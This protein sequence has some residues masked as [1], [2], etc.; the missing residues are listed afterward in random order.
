MSQISHL[1]LNGL[2]QAGICSNVSIWQRV[3]YLS[4]N[5]PSANSHLML[6]ASEMLQFLKSILFDTQVV[7]FHQESELSCSR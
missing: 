4:V 1:K 7:I 6:P 3:R 2:L 5:F